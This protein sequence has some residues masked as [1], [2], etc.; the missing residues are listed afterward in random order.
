MQKYND[1]IFV[2]VDRAQIVTEP[3]HP[4]VASVA[5]KAPP[6]V[7]SPQRR[8]S[9]AYAPPAL[10]HLIE[11]SHAQ[12]G[13]SREDGFSFRGDETDVLMFCCYRHL[14]TRRRHHRRVLRAIATNR[15]RKRSPATPTSVATLS[16]WVTPAK[17]RSPSHPTTPLTLSS[18]PLLPHQQQQVPM[19]SAV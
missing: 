7:S 1:V 11:A 14:F 19:P 3:P 18:L 9:K 17:P 12:V 13:W 16:I 2:A 15:V 4:A 10:A 8:I 6:E 5:R